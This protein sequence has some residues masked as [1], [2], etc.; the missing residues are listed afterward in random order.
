MTTGENADAG[1]VE[2]LF[3][4]VFPNGGSTALANVLLS[5]KGTLA[6][7][8]RAEGQWLS[9]AMSAPRARWDPDAVIDYAEVRARWMRVV[10]Q[11]RLLDDPNGAPPLVIEKSPPNMCRYRAL[12]SMLGDMKTDI[13]VMTRD[14][15][16][17]C[18]SWAQYGAERIDREWGWPGAPPNDDRSYHQALARIWIE[19]ARRLAAAR[20]DAVMWLRYE[21]F[22]ERPRAL[23]NDFARLIPRLA[24]ADPDGDI[25]VK[26]YPPQR[27]RNMNGEQIAMPVARPEGGDRRGPGRGR[28]F[29]GAAW[30]CGGAAMRN[31]IGRVPPRAEGSNRRT[32]RRSQASDCAQNARAP[33][34]RLRRKPTFGTFRPLFD[35][36]PVGAPWGKSDRGAAIRPNA[37]LKGRAANALEHEGA[38]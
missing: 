11:S 31:L 26:A 23:V 21:D 7:Y 22:A 35:G 5:A 8:G 20:D 37:D 28:G 24:A 34:R 6:L 32:A 10:R 2:W 1:S 16:A 33:H 38:L 29:R 18:A 19:R 9:P 14:P 12:R 17:T 3:L 13:A 30:L 25:A 15:Y 36:A 4:L 27:V